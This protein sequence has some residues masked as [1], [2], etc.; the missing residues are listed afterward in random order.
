MIRLYSLLGAVIGICGTQVFAQNL[1]PNPSFENFTSCPTGNGQFVGYV[2]DWQQANTATTD[3]MACS[4]NGN[5]AIQIS[6]ATGN[7]AVGIWGGAGHPSCGG[8]A[9]SEAI[10]IDL[11]A[12]MA[13]GKNYHLE[14]KV[15]VDPVGTSTQAPNDCVDFGMYFYNSSAPPPMTGWCCNPVTP[16]WRITGSLIPQGPYATFDY[17]I[18]GGNWDAVIIGPFCNSN[19]PNSPCNNYS[20]SRMYF[21]LDDVSVEEII[22]L[23]VGNVALQGKA[24]SGFHQLNWQVEDGHPFV[25]FVVERGENGEDFEVV[26]EQFAQLPSQKDYQFQDMSPRQGSN[27]YRLVGITADGTRSVSEVVE[28]RQG[29][30]SA[31]G[32]LLSYVYDR[33]GENL[34][35]VLDNAVADVYRLEVVDLQ[36]RIVKAAEWQLPAGKQIAELPVGEVAGG[37][38]VLRL[39]AHTAGIEWSAK[40]I[41]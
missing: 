11:D 33:G 9:Y 31:E 34:E 7:A 20:F 14:M 13:V 29:E 24:Y 36:G 39:R 25:R 28:L 2:E 10:R 23:D 37:M 32:G 41:H 16:Q 4:Y 15:R 17:V 21:N 5:S 8:S 27:F 1:I 12:R 6:A 26:E 40:W 3:Y 19:T 22:V 35:I 38:Y 18:P 30:N